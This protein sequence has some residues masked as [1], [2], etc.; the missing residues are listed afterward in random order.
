MFKIWNFLKSIPR[1]NHRLQ[2]LIVLIFTYLSL[3]TTIIPPIKV[4]ASTD[5]LKVTAQVDSC[6]V[7]ITVHPEKRI[8]STNNW[9]TILRV[10]IY[11]GSSYLG[12]YQVTT[13][14]SGT[15]TANICSSNLKVLPG[16]YNFYLKGYSHL[17]KAF[18]N[19][20]AFSTTKTTLNFATAGNL[21]AGETSVIYD[22]YINSLDLST[23][24][25]HL[26]TNDYKSDLNQDGKVN[27]LDISNTIYNF[28]K[29]G[30]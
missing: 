30:D 7:Q 21:L 8:P 15:G 27:S 18:L 10:E 28:F 6:I 16:N 25:N 22:N 29:H 24:I 20:P 11:S 4:E 17:R 2:I 23:Q 14:S 19:Y 3:T 13:D 26:Y 5:Q 12:S 9:G 1:S